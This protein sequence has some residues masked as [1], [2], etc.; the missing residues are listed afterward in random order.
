M[1]GVI[2]R[3]RY[4]LTQQISEGPIFT[5]FRAKDRVSGREVHVRLLRSPFDQE[6]ALVDHLR[7]T[8][9]ELSA[10]HAPTIE[11]MVD[12]D[13]H[14]GTPFLVSDSGTGQPF[15]ERLKRLAPYSVP[16][17]VGMA[18]QVLEALT[19]VHNAGFV[20]GEVTPANI[21][22][23]QDG[24]MTL[25]QPGLWV[26]YASSRFAGPAVLPVIAPYLAP[27]VSQG[28]MPSP[29]S[30]VYAVGVMLFEMLAGRQPFSGD[31]PIAMAS[32]HMT[33]PVPSL[34]MA[35][36]SVP[37]AVEELVRKAMSKDPNDRYATAKAMLNDLRI[38]QEAIRFGK[39]L[40]WPL[41]GLAESQ[42]QSPQAPLTIRKPAA[43]P[44]APAP[45]DNAASSPA[46]GKVNS[47]LD[48][49]D[50]LPVWLTATAYLALCALIVVIGGWVYWNI[51]QPKAIKV[52]SIVGVQVSEAQAQ[53]KAL[54]LTLRESRREPSE[55]QPEGIILDL[56]PAPGETVRENGSVYAVISSG[57]RFVQIP[58]LKGRSLDEARTLLNALDLRIQEPVEEQRSRQLDPGKI[59]RTVPESGARVE[60][61]SR[62]RLTVSSERTRE[63]AEAGR[64]R[65]TY[66]V[67]VTVPDGVGSVTVRVDLTDATGN[68]TLHEERHRSGD[69][70]EVEADG[71]GDPVYFRIFFN[72]DLVKSV[73][74][75][76]EKSVR[77]SSE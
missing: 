4:E 40:T 56:D 60:K 1:I 64:T 9:R 37:A 32:K 29:T 23:S 22:V 46:K 72:G 19:A 52:P 3:M 25:L 47:E 15:D 66:L 53:L 63:S 24:K 51:T 28:Q 7:S 26:T 44:G 38:V 33:A 5:L 36:A 43:T 62:V 73:E 65:A 35:N 50:R 31:T 13:E 67:R 58:D 2:L 55:R 48:L 69:A 61:G 77:G 30:D 74:K 45:S 39:P 21:L 75:S 10:I 8:I 16:V 59:L 57:S 12:L 49:S 68:R 76:P 70:F 41:A 6:T 11:R 18:V 20:H 34:R 14:E 42:S 17:A 71:F 27:E 54:G